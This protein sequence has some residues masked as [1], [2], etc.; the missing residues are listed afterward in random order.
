MSSRVQVD[1][2]DEYDEETGYV[3]VKDWPY[4]DDQMLRSDGQYWKDAEKKDEVLQRNE[5]YYGPDWIKQFRARKLLLAHDA[6]FQFMGHVAGRTGTIVKP[7]VLWRGGNTSATGGAVTQMLV[8]LVGNFHNFDGAGLPFG[9]SSSTVG[10]MLQRSREEQAK[11]EEEKKKKEELNKRMS[12]EESLLLP[13]NKSAIERV[14]QKTQEAGQPVRAQGNEVRLTSSSS[15]SSAARQDATT[16]SS[17]ILNPTAA[18][19]GG[20]KE[21][22][23][24]HPK[25]PRV[26][27]PSSAPPS[28]SPSPAPGA[29]ASPAPAGQPYVLGI[30]D[31]WLRLFEL[32]RDPRTTSTQ[33]QAWTKMYE[34]SN[35]SEEEKF[36]D[37]L[38]RDPSKLSQYLRDLAEIQRILESGNGLADWAIAPENAGYLFMEDRLKTALLRAITVVRDVCSKEWVTQEMLITSKNPA[39]VDLFAELVAY[40][41][42]EYSTSGYSSRVLGADF[43]KRQ[44]EKYAYIVGKFKLLQRGDPL[45]FSHLQRRGYDEFAEACYEQPHLPNGKRLT[46]L[47]GDT[48]ADAGKP[49]Q[50]KAMFI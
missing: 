37:E 23:R 18:E 25:P 42:I 14:L 50:N 47:A 20:S 1:V 9:Q 4:R 34:E 35:K 11:M 45:S 33:L 17:V 36:Y 26:M 24:A 48:W 39:V 46:Q 31:K 28:A 5:Q 49:G 10:Q 19:R 3:P 21:V 30:D 12:R 41:V 8:E 13:Q 7:N 29:P 6:V 22:R 40:Y 2:P 32:M 43:S 15:S 27:L 16:D 44:K 38:R